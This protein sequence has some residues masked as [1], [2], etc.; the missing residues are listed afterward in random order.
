MGAT[1]AQQCIHPG[2]PITDMISSSRVPNETTW[3]RDRQ[4]MNYMQ[5]NATGEIYAKLSYAWRMAAAFPP[6]TISALGLS[7]H[8]FANLAIS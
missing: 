4:S 8:V 3:S 1:Q 5:Q 7:R 6:W 2:R